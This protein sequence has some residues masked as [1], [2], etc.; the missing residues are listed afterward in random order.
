MTIYFREAVFAI[1]HMNR[2]DLD[3]ASAKIEHTQ[4]FI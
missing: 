3:F 2:L 1:L 4:E